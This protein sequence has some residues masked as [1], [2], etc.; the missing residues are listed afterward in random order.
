MA[1]IFIGLDLAWSPRNRSGAAVIVEEADGGQLK[2]PPVLLHTDDQIVAYIEEHAGASP[3]IVAVDA[4]LWVPNIRGQRLA[5]TELAHA[6][7]RY[8]AGA[9]PANRQRLA[10]AGVV[11]GEALVTALQ[12]RGFSHT[13]TITPGVA[14][15]Q[16]IEVFPHPA[17][18][19]L[20]GLERTLKYKARANRSRDLR[21]R[22][23]Q[24]YQQHL[25]ALTTADPQLRGHAEFVQQ[26]VARLRGQA[27][28][29][30]EDQV[31][32]LFCA[33]IALYAWHWGSTRCRTF[34]TLAEGYI[35]T[36]VPA[37]MWPATT[38][39]Q[40]DLALCDTA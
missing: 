28:K 20:F 33:Y 26:D 3:A 27:L 24:H 18:I 2:A 37:T 8:E 11:R 40:L 17:M 22:A 21:L 34:G 31:D 19:A 6:F 13:V 39:P 9:H 32:A 38:S 14:V 4:P 5:E 23:W 1:M 15:R 12:Q 16:V 36:P 30:Y 7:R 35:F 10:I 25:F 29:A